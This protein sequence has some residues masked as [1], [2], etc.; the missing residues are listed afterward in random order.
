MGRPIKKGVD[1]FP[2]FPDDGSDGLYLLETKYGNDGYAFWYKMR[3]K[4]TKTQGHILYMSDVLV[5]AAKAHMDDK[6]AMEMLNMCAEAG[7]IDKILW[8]N[9]KVIW[10]Q[11]V[12]DSLKDVYK[13][14]GALPPSK[15]SSIQLSDKQI[16]EAVQSELL[17][18]DLTKS[19]SKNKSETKTNIESTVPLFELKEPEIEPESLPPTPLGKICTM[20][21]QKIGML[22]PQFSDALKSWLDEYTEDQILNAI[23]KAHAW[24]GHTLGYLQKV[25]MD[26]KNVQKPKLKPITGMKVQKDE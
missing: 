6:T 2:H 5:L 21:E 10:S 22:T 19:E 12:V 9:E 15:P 26:P 13:K 24:G 18:Q 4:I 11:S 17:W 14:R 3:E 23:D 16:N 7:D 20:Y 1:A 25:L 8:K